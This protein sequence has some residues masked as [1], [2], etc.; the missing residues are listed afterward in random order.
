[1]LSLVRGNVITIEPGCYVP[2][3]DAFPKAFHGMGIRIEVTT[4]YL[5]RSKSSTDASL[6]GPQDA[7]AFTA[8]GPLNLS[9]NAPKEVVDVEGVCQGLL[10]S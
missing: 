7:V 6:S 1:M 3:S 5:I 2:A 10:Q 8:E 9:A 4:Y